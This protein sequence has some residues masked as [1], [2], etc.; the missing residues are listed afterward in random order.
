MPVPQPGQHQNKAMANHEAVRARAEAAGHGHV[1]RFWDK[2]TDAQ[3]QAL[4]DDVAD[5]DVEKLND[6]FKLTMAL[7]AS[8]E[9]PEPLST[10]AKLAVQSPETKT[11]WF[12]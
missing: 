12:E 5:I 7:T 1:F 2:L 6:N 11:Q 3:K 4:V 8:T 9:P 10:V